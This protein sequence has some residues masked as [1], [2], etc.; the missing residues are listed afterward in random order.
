MLLRADKMK[1]SK[2]IGSG[3]R[4]FVSLNQRESGFAVVEWDAGSVGVR[5][6]CAQQLASKLASWRAD[7]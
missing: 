2:S 1:M 5:K 3:N 4:V 6:S 7:L